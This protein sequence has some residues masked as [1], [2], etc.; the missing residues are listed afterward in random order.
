MSE[1]AFKKGSKMV[2]VNLSAA[3]Y[4]MLYEETMRRG[5]SMAD[6][7]RQLVREADAAAPVACVYCGKASI[8]RL[9]GDDLCREHAIAWCRGEGP[10][11][12]E[13]QV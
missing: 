1:V 6:T 4:R 9:D 13:D 2:T 3:D 11:Q 7:L 5:V 8:T 10:F 12:E